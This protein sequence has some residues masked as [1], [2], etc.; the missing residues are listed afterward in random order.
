MGWGTA[1]E[2]PRGASE[3]H[4]KAVVPRPGV[5]L[6]SEAISG[7]RRT[8]S[9]RQRFGLL[10]A[11]ESWTPTK[12]DFKELEIG[13]PPC[14]ARVGFVWFGVLWNQGRD[15]VGAKSTKIFEES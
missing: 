5:A 11:P 2:G 7:E 9:Q 15:K 8:V 13:Q 6:S 4:R 3:S 12:K 10:I 1:L 14:N